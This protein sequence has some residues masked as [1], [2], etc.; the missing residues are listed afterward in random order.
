MPQKLSPSRPRRPEWLIALGDHATV[1]AGRVAATVDAALGFPRLRRRFAARVGYAPDFANPR[2]FNEK[3]N[4]RKLYD[5]ASVYPV[6]CDKVRMPDYLA[7]RFGA[8]R[9]AAL[10]PT[11][12]LVTDRPTAK[13][14]AA[15]GTGVAIKANHGSG[16]VQI[17]P[18]GAQPDWHALAATARG[19][20]RQVYGLTRQEWAYWSIPPR[21]VVEDLVLKAD[22]TPADDI[23]IAVM[24]GRASYLFVEADRF[25]DHRLSYYTPDWQPMAVAMGAYTVG[26]PLPRPPRLAA[27]VALAEEIGRDFDYIRVDIL[28]GVQDFRVNEL[29]IYRSSGLARIEPEELDWKWGAEWRHRPYAGVW[30]PRA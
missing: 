19:W 10:V 26:T 12:R 5:H 7:L 15:A 3:I 14:L 1:A 13:T 21:I 24:D 6:I 16:W 18:A 22:G 4:W 11:R 23:K 30:P 25:S 29:T 17:V 20:L 28:N 2:S 8:D 9:A 27:M